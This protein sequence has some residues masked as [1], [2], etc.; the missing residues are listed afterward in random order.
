MTAAAKPRPGPARKARTAQLIRFIR[1][2]AAQSYDLHD[3]NGR[4]SM[5]TPVQ[6]VYRRRE[7]TEEMRAEI[8]AQ[9]TRLARSRSEGVES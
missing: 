3:Q 5:Q 4:D 1:W 6:N 9:L 8:D 2:A 7:P